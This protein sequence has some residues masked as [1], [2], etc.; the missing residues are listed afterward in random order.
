MI[1]KAYQLTVP[2]RRE[3][4]T[5]NCNKTFEIFPFISFFEKPANCLIRLFTTNNFISERASTTQKTYFGDGVS[6]FFERI[7]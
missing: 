4:S 1:F 2:V 3:T 7:I 6:N 5:E